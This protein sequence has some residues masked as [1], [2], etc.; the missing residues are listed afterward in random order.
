MEHFKKLSDK[1]KSYYDSH[2]VQRTANREALMKIL[3]DYKKKSVNF[4]NDFKKPISTSRA[5]GGS[6]KKTS[7]KVPKKKTLKK[8]K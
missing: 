2:Q 7:K 4:M 6:K 1:A 3:D 8:K 5:K